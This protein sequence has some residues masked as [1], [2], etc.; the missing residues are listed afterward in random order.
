MSRPPGIFEDPNR[1]V[2]IMTSLDGDVRSLI[3]HLWFE[4]ADGWSEMSGFLWSPDT[5]YDAAAWIEDDIGTD[6]VRLNDLIRQFV[7]AVDEQMEDL[8]GDDFVFS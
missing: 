1:K 6:K 2:I 4:G 8:P 3:N 5:E 7:I